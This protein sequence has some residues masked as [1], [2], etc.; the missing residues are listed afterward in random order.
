VEAEGADVTGEAPGPGEPRGVSF[1]GGALD[2]KIVASRILPPF[3]PLRPHERVLNLGSGEGPQVVV[4]Q[5]SFGSMTCADYDLER[6]RFARRSLGRRGVTGAGFLRCDAAEL[7]FAAETFDAALVLDLLEHLARPE[8]ALGELARVL[9]SGGRLLASFPLLFDLY[10]HALEA[11]L[12]LR[13][14]VLRLERSRPPV[15]AWDRHRP[16]RPVREWT[17][18]LERSGFRIERMRASTLFPPL[19]LLGVRRFWI[20]IGAIRRVD[21]W[22]SSLPGVRRLGQA[23]LVSATRA[24][25]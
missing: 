19:Q 24:P 5:G 7:P 23:M 15:P 25:L 8:A 20:E 17:R 9:R 2:G 22:L 1:R 10:D 16:E 6:L 12:R 13:A 4:Y 18:L 14:R 11:A 3:F 21:G